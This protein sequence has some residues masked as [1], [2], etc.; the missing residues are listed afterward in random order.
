MA[1]VKI[2]GHASGTGVLTVTAPNTSTDRTITLPDA[3]GTLLNSDG[4]GSSL[5]GVGVA[6]ITS[7]AD[8]T[9]I[10]IDSSERVGIGT[11][12]PLT[13]SLLHI[14][15]NASS[16]VSAINNGLL[17]VENNTGVGIGLLSNNDRQ[18]TIA[19]GD[20]EDN[21]V[22]F[23]NYGHDTNQMSFNVNAAERMRITANGVTFNGDTAAANALD[24]YD[25]GH[26]TNQM[27]FNVNAAERMRITANG[28]TFNG[29]TA[30]A[31]ALDDYEEGVHQLS[32]TGSTS[33]SMTL[34]SGYEYLAYTKIGRLVTVQG[35]WETTAKNSASG[36]MTFSLPF[37]AGSFN[38]QSGVSS[39]V[40]S[41]YRAG[42]NFNNVRIN[43]FSSGNTATIWYN[44]GG[45]GDSDDRVE[46]QNIDGTVEGYMCLT[47]MTA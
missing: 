1:K 8:A 12:S 43:V 2:Q 26:D 13:N 29:D 17:L 28:V 41:L 22:G 3:T 9:A 37:T 42:A 19:F 45:T 24:D 18:Q 10:T 14:Q 6:G 23:I 33:G 7:S 36:T 27:S 44:Q 46:M 5:T 35:R 39:G 40:F 30:A 25:Y 38:G 47:Y 15:S 20:P 16:G 4:D 34:K 31:N 11:G 21:D 32:I